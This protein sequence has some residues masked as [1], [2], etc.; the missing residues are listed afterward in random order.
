MTTELKGLELART[1]LT[2][3]VEVR[4]PL[5]SDE[6]TAVWNDTPLATTRFWTI[7][8]DSVN[9]TVK[10]FILTAAEIMMGRIVLGL[11]GKHAKEMPLRTGIRW[12]KEVSW[13]A[14]A[15]AVKNTEAPDLASPGMF[16]RVKISS[17]FNLMKTVVSSTE[18]VTIPPVNCN[19]FACTLKKAGCNVIL[20]TLKLDRTGSEN[21]SVRILSVISKPK[22]VDRKGGIVSPIYVST[23]LALVSKIVAKK[24][25]AISDRGLKS[26]DRKEVDRSL[27][28]PAVILIIAYIYIYKYIYIWNM[29]LLCIYIYIH[30]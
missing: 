20:V 8:S 9:V 22:V 27:A 2:P 6:L 17:L 21:I 19:L 11:K 24:F 30:R 10:A 1:G 16:L 3:E 14:V 4:D 18:K 29:Y 12:L 13:A 7:I 23:C 26:R 25:P 5:M 15:V 28:K